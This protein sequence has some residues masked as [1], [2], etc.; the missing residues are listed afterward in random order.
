LGFWLD[1]VGWILV[2]AVTGTWLVT[3][4]SMLVMLAD[5]QVL[6]HCRVHGSKMGFAWKA[7]WIR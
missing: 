1:R 2:N 3:L 4:V 6:F 7:A 5:F